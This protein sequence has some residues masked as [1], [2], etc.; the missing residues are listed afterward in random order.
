MESGA[1]NTLDPHSSP[2]PPSVWGAQNTHAHDIQ[3]N[4]TTPTVPPILFVRQPLTTP[5]RSFCC[6]GIEAVQ[7]VTC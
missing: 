1:T 5:P 6:A 2:S 7:L 4:Y 3:P